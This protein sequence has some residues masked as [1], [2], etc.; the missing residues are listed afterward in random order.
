MPDQIQPDFEQAIEADME[1]LATEVKLHKESPEMQA[2]SGHELIKKSLQTMA[3]STS[4]GQAQ[5]EPLAIGN[6]I[7][8]PLPNY[9]QDAP[10]ET[11]L[12]RE[13]LLGKAFREGIMR[14]SNE[15]A[16]SSPFVLDAFH[17]ALAGKLYPELKRRGI[18]E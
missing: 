8:N 17:D 10:A 5:D 4:S 6:V 7:H 1:R 13:Y 9:A 18:L 14:A 3:H 16:R 12:E 15:A 11:K 2:A